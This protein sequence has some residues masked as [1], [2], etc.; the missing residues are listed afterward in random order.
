MYIILI[1][2]NYNILGH[3]SKV[4][5]V[6]SNGRSVRRTQYIIY[7]F[8]ESVSYIYNIIRY[9]SLVRFKYQLIQLIYATVSPAPSNEFFFFFFLIKSGN[10][11]RVRFVLWTGPVRPVVCAIS[12]PKLSYKISLL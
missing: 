1:L 8:T 4:K 3:R 6:K 11:D 12:L 10:I 7:T 5:N 9:E 2:F